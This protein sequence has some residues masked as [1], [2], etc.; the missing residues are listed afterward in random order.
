MWLT[1]HRFHSQDLANGAEGR[2]IRVINEYDTTKP[3]KFTYVSKMCFNRNVPNYEKDHV[4]SLSCCDCTDDCYNR[5]ECS[6]WQ[7]TLAGLQYSDQPHERF[8]YDDNKRLQ[9]MVS[10]AIYECNVNCKCSRKCSN[11]VVQHPISHN[12]ELYKTHSCGWGVRCLTD[13]P[14]GAFVCCYFGDIMTEE[15][16]EQL[17]K[18]HGDTYLAQLNF[19]ELGEEFKEGFES[20]ARLSPGS[21]GNKAYR[22]YDEPPPTK[23]MR[24]LHLNGDASQISS[25]GSSSSN[26]TSSSIDEDEPFV[27]V[28]SYFPRTETTNESHPTRQLFGKR[29]TVYIIDGKRCGNIGRFFNVRI[30]HIFQYVARVT[31]DDHRDECFISFHQF[32]SDVSSM[33]N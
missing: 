11:R 25:G 7:L 16:C 12:F 24:T 23:K 17:A 18:K 4:D 13:L 33:K 32:H 30:F 14:K 3:E 6:C 29:E 20:D 15:H 8:A 21:S 27:A 9:N 2:P 22:N 31:P 5:F 19:I 26:G 28:I 10:T 1:I